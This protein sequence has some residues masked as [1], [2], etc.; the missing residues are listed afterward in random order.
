MCHCHFDY[1]KHPTLSMFSVTHP[2]L[3]G[4]GSS[5]QYLLW[6]SRSSEESSGLVWKKRESQNWTRSGAATA[7]SWHPL[8]RESEERQAG[9]HPGQAQS[10]EVS[11][12]E[13][14][15][16]YS[17][18]LS[19]QVTSLASTQ[20]ICNDFTF[21]TRIFVSYGCQVV[22]RLYNEARSMDNLTDCVN[23]NKERAGW[24]CR[25]G[26]LYT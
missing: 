19:L 18:I 23:I 26:W 21:S 2:E 8:G 15:C 17:I 11:E 22:L 16:C 12:N 9:L 7:W 14:K 1:P 3:L 10:V 20:Y 4:L 25:W 6:Y 5:W 13:S 24:D